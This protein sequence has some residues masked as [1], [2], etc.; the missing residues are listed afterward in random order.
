[1]GKGFCWPLVCWAEGTPLG[2]ALG[3]AVFGL[4]DRVGLGRIGWT[5]SGGVGSAFDRLDRREGG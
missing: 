5:P 4:V 1:M 3:R 2:S